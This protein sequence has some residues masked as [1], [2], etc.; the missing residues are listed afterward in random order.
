M[1]IS[2]G[3]DSISGNDFF[4]DPTKHLSIEGISGMSKSTLLV[5]LF[6]EHIRQRNGGLF[7]D[8][9]GDS[10]DQ[11][12]KLIQKK[13]GYEASSGSTPMLRLFRRSTQSTSI[14]RKN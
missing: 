13:S 12:A 11:I 1:D 4:I 14:R 3:T 10:A 8:P 5:N 9:H 2:L 6:I 7:I